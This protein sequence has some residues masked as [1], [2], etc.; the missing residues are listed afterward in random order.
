MHFTRN[1]VAGS[2]VL[3]FLIGFLAFSTGLAYIKKIE[4][5]L[6]SSEAILNWKP[7][8]GTTIRAVDNTVI[9][10]HSSE[11]REFV[12]IDNMPT[13]IINGFVAAEDGQY[14]NHSGINPIA[15]GRA[16]LANFKSDNGRLVGAS[17][18]TQQV[19]KNIL[20]TPERTIDRKI[21]EAILA[22]KINKEVGKRRI[23]EIYLNQIYL[24]EG[25]Y[26]V[27][28]A[29]KSYFNKE[30][31]ELTI[32]EVAVIAALPK[33]P[34]V[35]NPVKNMELTIAR[36]NYVLG[37]MMEDGY[38][39]S[40]QEQAAKIEPIILMSDQETG[41]NIEYAFK[42]PEEAVRRA[43][44]S[45]LGKDR[46]Y[47]E[48]GDVRTTIIPNLQRVVHAELRAGLVREDRRS[49]W[50]GPLARNIKIPINWE[51]PKLSPPPGAEDWSVGVVTDVNN[52]AL[53]ETQSG[54][55][56]ITGKSLAWLTS[57]QSALGVLKKGDA[58]LVGDIG[59]GMELLQIPKVE[60][61]VVVLDP[62][63]GAIRAMEGG[64]SF[65]ASE[66]NR[67]IQA[68]RQTGSIFKSFVY[69]A[70]L[71]LGFNAMSPVLDSPIA[72]DQGGSDWRPSSHSPGD[73][74]SVV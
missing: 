34:S 43:L 45:S 3:A 24:G 72:I 19:V 22:L 21:K 50:S 18:I 49:G 35:I 46:V 47:S 17:T 64:F 6:P 20:L 58:V 68:K 11:F 59:E 33:A 40:E 69:L 71:E 66:F 13:M 37:R 52:N 28:A 54:T 62:L 67:A 65:E 42:S 39:T 12:S 27:A 60:G 63:S 36:R 48:G 10:I 41:G 31:S 7:S 57:R 5:T 61:A 56:E 38:I 4:P 73:R 74:K 44:V 53:I 51:N 1:L 8:V 16:A 25:A 9:G 14:W 2:T 15:I 30:L 55:I 23:L 32:N 29:A 70:A 26:G